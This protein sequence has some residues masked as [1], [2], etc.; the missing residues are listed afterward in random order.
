MGG[1]VFS[2]EQ[3]LWINRQDAKGKR[4]KTSYTGAKTAE[5]SKKQFNQIIF[6]WK[7]LKMLNSCEVE[8]RFYHQRWTVFRYTG[9]LRN[10]SNRHTRQNTK[11]A[12]LRWVYQNSISEFR[13]CFW[14]T[15]NL[16]SCAKAKA[17]TRKSIFG[18]ANRSHKREVS[19]LFNDYLLLSNA[20]IFDQIGLL[21][22][23]RIKWPVQESGCARV[24][25]Q[26]VGAVKLSLLG[27]ARARSGMLEFCTCREYL[28]A[29]LY[30]YTLPM[31]DASI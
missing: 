10:V 14:L 1:G 30:V 25:R 2:S 15:N 12:V 22:Y 21:Y 27:S 24:V 29:T 31:W 13:S 18:I 20:P 8:S 28:L 9:N 3:D 7:F 19:F 23:S 6:R 26:A 5:I 17:R 11:M 16:P 4:K